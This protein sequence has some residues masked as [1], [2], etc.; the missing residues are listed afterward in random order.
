M[1]NNFHDGVLQINAST[2]PIS[3]AWELACNH[4]K[5]KKTLNKLIE[6]LADHE[7]L[8]INRN[9]Y[10]NHYHFAEVVWASSFLAKNEFPLTRLFDHSLI[11][12]L[13]ATFHD[14]EHPGRANKEPFELEKASAYFFKQ[15]WKNNSLFVENI[16]TMQPNDIEQA[17]TE[18]ILFTDFSH[19]QQKVWN[20][21]LNRKDQESLDLKM[22][23]LKKLLTEADI[24][25]SCLPYY[26]Y[27]KTGL[28][29]KEAG[30]HVTQEEQW[31]LLLGFLQDYGLKTFTS[32]AA[33]SLNVDKVVIQFTE[34]LQKHKNDFTQGIKLQEEIEAIFPAF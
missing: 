13:A 18:L 19:G 3:K 7:N 34:F 20:D 10:H 22:S 23:R 16:L 12:L 26:G 28:I 4:L 1:T 25:M 31:N 24:L 5:M 21:Y 33:K 27:H 2:K 29:I 15:W 14:A 9:A 30:R 6:V 32:D 17:V 11:L 8:F